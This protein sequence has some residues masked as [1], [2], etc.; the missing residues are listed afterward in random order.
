[1]SV[2]RGEEWSDRREAPYDQQWALVGIADK[3]YNFEDLKYSMAKVST[4]RLSASKRVGAS[5]RDCV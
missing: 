4:M 3:V 1:V 2:T 5:E